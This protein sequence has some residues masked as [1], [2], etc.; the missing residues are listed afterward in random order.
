VS[1]ELEE[2]GQPDLKQVLTDFLTKLE[3]RKD[4]ENTK[5]RGEG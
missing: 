1:Y 4:S 5:K 2:I 3:H